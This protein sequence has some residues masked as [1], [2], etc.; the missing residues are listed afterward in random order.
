MLKGGTV[1]FQNAK[2]TETKKNIRNNLRGEKHYKFIHY[3]L[4]NM[5]MNIVCH[6]LA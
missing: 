5:A 2:I 1:Q 3:L 6:Y 4:Y